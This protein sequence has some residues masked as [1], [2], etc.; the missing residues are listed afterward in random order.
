MQ[1]GQLMKRTGVPVDTIRY[2]ENHGI[3]PPAPRRESGYRDYDEGDVARIHFVRR[4]KRLGFSLREIRDLLALSGRPSEDM[5]A[6]RNA[7]T[8]KLADIELRIGELQRV[9]DGLLRLIEACPGHG[10]RHGCPILAALSTEDGH[11]QA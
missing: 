4:A 9:R 7:A 2:Y 10:D 3:L 11:E 6:V 8:V 5:A 1:I